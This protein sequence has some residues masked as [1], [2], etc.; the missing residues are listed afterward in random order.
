MTL[1]RIIQNVM[2][3]V[4]RLSLSLSLSQNNREIWWCSSISAFPYILHPNLQL[5]SVCMYIEHGERHIHILPTST[6]YSI[7]P[8][9][10]LSRNKSWILIFLSLS[11]NPKH[12]IRTDS[13]PS[14]DSIHVWLGRYHFSCTL[15]YCMQVAVGGI[16]F[17]IGSFLWGKLKKFRR[18]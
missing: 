7:Y 16:R 11:H 4:T 9:L 18:P 2:S 17:L 13:T 10:F 6:P 8:S 5:V 12:K 14:Q 3:P 15:Q 1:Q